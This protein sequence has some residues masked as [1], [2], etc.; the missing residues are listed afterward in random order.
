MENTAQHRTSNGG[1]QGR[2]AV[3]C[4]VKTYPKQVLK[5]SRVLVVVK[6]ST[7]A[8]AYRWGPPSGPS[9]FSLVQSTL[10]M[11]RQSWL[12]CSTQ[13]AYLQGWF[14]AVRGKAAQSLVTPD[15]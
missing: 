2:K 1:R 13:E 4:V 10:G 14:Q 9:R 3:S 7:I 11:F 5:T 6:L 12:L 8:S 15:L